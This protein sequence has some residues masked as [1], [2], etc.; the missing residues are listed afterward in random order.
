MGDKKLVA[1][2]G[3]F[4]GVHSAHGKLLEETVRQASITGAE[5]AAVMFDRRPLDMVNGSE[6]ELINTAEDRKDII[7]RLYGIENTIS[8]RFTADFMKIKWDE[9]IKQLKNEYNVSC[10]VAGYDFR[11]GH[12]GEGDCNKL[13][14]L[15][16]E[17]DIGCR[18][19]EKVEIDGTA[20]SSTY[21][22]ELIK[23]G[24]MKRANLFL[25]HPHTLS[26]TV[27][28]GRKLGRTMDFPTANMLIPDGVIVP[29]KGVYSAK[30]HTWDGGEY[31]AVTNIG[32]R[33]T[34]NGG[35][36][37]TVESHLLDFSGNLYGTR[38]RV[39][40]LDFIRP[41]QKFSDLDELKRQISLDILRVRNENQPGTITNLELK[42][43]QDEK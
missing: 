16:G 20:V 35:D 18:V 23:N 37:I 32:S 33:P 31:T 9:F 22:R 25:G 39:E 11:F 36:D 42:S 3:F 24:D 8:I 1:A 17:L 13:R 30:F 10:V 2:L 43:N 26:G 12:M 7:S 28:D 29:K 14:A 19:I 15:C 41:E 34:V 5:P 6:T 4:D 40:F 38:G 21:I 27:A